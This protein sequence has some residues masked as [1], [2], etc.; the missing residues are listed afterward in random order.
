MYSNYV[1]IYGCDGYLQTEEDEYFTALEEYLSKL[2]EEET[3]IW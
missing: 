1:N 3:W 2:T